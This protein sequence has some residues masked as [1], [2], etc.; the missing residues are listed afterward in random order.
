MQ[1]LQKAGHGVQCNNGSRALY[2]QPS[3]PSETKILPFPEPASPGDELSPCFIA[4]QSSPDVQQPFL[5]SVITFCPL[6]PMRADST[7]E[8]FKIQS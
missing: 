8:A 6:C 1:G 7:A 2:L 3:S 5:Q 4:A